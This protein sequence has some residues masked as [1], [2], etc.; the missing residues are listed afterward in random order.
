MGDTA[1]S[2]EA[3]VTIAERVGYP[4]LVRPS[5]VL[6]GRA[7]EIVRDPRDL[8]RYMTWALG[9]NPRGEVLVDKYLQGIEVEVDAI[10]D[11]ETVVIPGVMQHVERAGVHSGD[12]YAVYPA[13]GIEPGEQ[14]DLIDYTIRIARHFEIRGLLNIQFVVHRGKVYVLEV[15]PRASRTVP[16]LSK[17]TGVPMVRLATRVM[18]G[19]SLESMGQVT[20]L[21]PAA[22][23]VAVKAPVFSMAKL[24]AVDSYLG[25]EMKS[26]GEVMG[27]DLTLHRALEKAF[28]AAGLG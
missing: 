2:V 23:L 24:S 25:P 11:G 8:E 19:E 20:G 28:L 12:S 1:T 22:P 14:A 18:L 9:A 17:V 26:T 5:F 15:N 4:V 16:F 21:V 13:P 10:S 7:M 3:A 6:G 27:V